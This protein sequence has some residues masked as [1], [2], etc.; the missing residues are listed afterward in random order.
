MPSYSTVAVTAV[1]CFALFGSTFV[2]SDNDDGGGTIKN[3]QLN[4]G[5]IEGKQTLKFLY[6]YSCGYQKA[7]D[8]YSGILSEKYPEL[9]II[10][11]N[12]NP[13]LMH[14]VVAKI[15]GILKMII[16]IAIAS[17]INF[18]EYIGKEQPRLWQWCTTNK[19]YACL[20]V[21][22]GSN[23]F[24]GILISTGA[25]E[26]FFNDIPVWSKLDTG[27]IPQPAELFQISDNYMLFDST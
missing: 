10:G 2:L 24:E 7:F 17:G 5:P 15:L 6:C 27:R 25:F 18:F 23:M 22:F 19:V 1:Y 9:H 14:L 26:L 11:A 16:I 4:K 3:V 21:F 13:S 12:Y 8:H 20:V